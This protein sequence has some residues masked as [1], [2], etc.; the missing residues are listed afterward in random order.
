MTEENRLQLLKSLKLLSSIPEDDLVELG[1]LLKTEAYPDGK[2][3]FEEGSKDDSLY[4]VSGGNVRIA[5]KLRSHTGGGAD[6]KE[7]AILGPGDCFGEMALVESVTRSA[8]AIASGE[9]VLFRLT[10]HDLDGWLK[11]HPVPATAFYSHLV[12]TL[13]HRLRNSTDELTLLFDLSHLLL[14]PCA[15]PKDLL[16]KVMHRL[17]QY[18][19]DDWCAGVYVYNEFNEEMDLVD[20][21]RDYESVKG[22]LEVSES[23]ETNSWL[24]DSTYQVIFP[25][26]KR[27]MGFIVFHRSRPLNPEQQ[28]E[29]ARTLTTTARLITSAL[30]NIGHRTEEELRSRLKTNTQAS[31]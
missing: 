14:D 27:V 24:D 20:I 9:S 23:P 30:E 6:Y 26:K 4:F 1:T 12:K 8:D 28:N 25:G 18:L 5:K 22:K 31:I 17:M 16:D 29:F 13:S 19:E 15:S 7:L 10:R 2:T 11:E 21:E 3:I